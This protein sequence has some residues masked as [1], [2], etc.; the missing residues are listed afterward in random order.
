MKTF[1]TTVYSD[2]ASNIYDDIYPSN[3]RWKLLAK[4]ACNMYN[5]IYI[6]SELSTCNSV[7]WPI[8]PISAAG[9]YVVRC[10]YAKLRLV[11]TEIHPRP[12]RLSRETSGK[13]NRRVTYILYPRRVFCLSIIPT[14]SQFGMEE[15][16]TVS[17]YKGG[18]VSTFYLPP[19]FFWGVEGGIFK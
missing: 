1:D 15:L 7:W 4:N 9:L 10:G 8:L 17:N 13:S 6:Y 3:K 12:E 14:P 18:W 5:E 19:P 16:Y 11:K 2:G